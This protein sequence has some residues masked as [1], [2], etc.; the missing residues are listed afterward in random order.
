MVAR[1]LMSV[2]WQ[3]VPDAQRAQRDHVDLGLDS[4]SLSQV[5]LQGVRLIDSGVKVPEADTNPLPGAVFDVDKAV[6]CGKHNRPLHKYSHTQAPQ[7]AG[8]SGPS[9]RGSWRPSTKPGSV[10][11]FITYVNERAGL[12]VV[13]RRLARDRNSNSAVILDAGSRWAA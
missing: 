6:F 1:S 12:T 4:L 8:A 10:R 5:F 2:S 3:I 7:N 11:S 13:S 9:F